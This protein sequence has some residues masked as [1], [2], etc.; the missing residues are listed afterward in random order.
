MTDNERKHK[1]QGWKGLELARA[2][3]EEVGYPMLKQQ[4]PQYMDRASAGLVGEGSECFGFDDEISRDHDFGARFCIWLPDDLYR[5]IGER[6]QQAYEHLALD[7]HGYPVLSEP[8]AGGAKRS[9]VFSVGGF[10]GGLLGGGTLPQKEEDWFGFRESALAAATNGAVFYDSGGAFSEIRETL[11][12]YYPENV[13][14]KKLAVNLMYM[15]QTGQVNYARSIRRGELFTADLCI[16]EFIRA[17]IS[18]LYL[19]NRRYMPYY[20]WAKAGLA[21]AEVFPEGVDMLEQLQS[22]GQQTS[23]WQDIGADPQIINKQDEKVLCIEA[24]CQRIA[25]ELRKQRLSDSPEVFLTQQALQVHGRITNRE[26]LWRPLRMPE[27]NP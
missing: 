6:M 10:Y 16:N 19:L 5:D 24:F 22:L 9:G 17:A 27:M 8:A 18:S 21:D 13:R 4:F 12:A 23:A 2:Y 25:E 26:I 7:F 1:A 20:K 3:F 11:K 15:A 14:K